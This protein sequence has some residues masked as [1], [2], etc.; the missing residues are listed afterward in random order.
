MSITKAR[1]EL[2]RA[3]Q[4]IASG[5]SEEALQN[6]DQAIRE[7]EP[8]RLLTTTEAAEALGV[9][10]VNTIKGW[11]HTGYL[12]GVGRGSR[13]MIPLAEVE[14]IQNSDQVR[15]IRASDVLH[16]ASRDFS[17]PSGLDDEQLRDLA[18]SRL[19][20]LPWHTDS[21]E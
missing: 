2:Q 7:M 20:K 10:S 5:K 21:C 16:E 4:L 11:C 1:E 14:R 17:L 3:R 12:R 18:A 19:G 15:A 13:I 6:L 9:R 8:E